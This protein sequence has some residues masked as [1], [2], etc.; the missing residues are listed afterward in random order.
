MGF[1]YN[2]ARQNSH[3]YSKKLKQAVWSELRGRNRDIDN[4]AAF[5]NYI[6]SLY[7][8]CEKYHCLPCPGSL[9]EQRWDYMF[10]FDIIV[11]QINKK[12]DEERHKSRTKK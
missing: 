6:I 2:I 11:S 3:L 8:K 5:V 4:H 7:S 9:E 10:Y 1:L 12:Q